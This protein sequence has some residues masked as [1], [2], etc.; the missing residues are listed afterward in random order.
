MV[1]NP[2]VSLFDG[3]IEI[4]LYG[5]FIAIGI[6]LCL[7][8]FFVYTKKKGMPQKVQDFT[9]IIV[10]VAIALGFL[11]AKLYQ[12]IYNW[13]DRGYFDFYS[14]GITAM[15]GFIGGAATLL[16]LYF[17]I[18]N[19]VFKGEQKGLHVREFNKTLLVAPICIVIAHAFGRIGC[20][21][22]GCCHGEYLG[23]EYVAGG[24]W[25][26]GTVDD[27]RTWGYFVPTQLYEAVFLFVL[28]AVLSVLYFKGSNITMQ[29][30]LIAYG[31]WRIIIEIFRT[32][33]RGAIILGLAPSQWQS[34]L[35]IAGG[36]AM[37]LIY[38]YLKIPFVIKN[39]DYALKIGRPKKP[40]NK[41]VNKK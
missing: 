2:V 32:D 27:V 5:V 19:L 14:A 41:K 7:V 29:I 15:G 17:P 28:F 4:Y 40:K 18:G 1:P 26:R 34:I 35:F 39:G 20:L 12:A 11:F 23:Q 24:M 6:L 22:A 16:V 31:V 10:L 21:M 33:Y 13:I 8:V 38:F 37:L 30:Y 3:K 9:F 36:I 25:M